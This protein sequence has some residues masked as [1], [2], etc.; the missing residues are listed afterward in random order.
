MSEYKSQHERE[1]RKDQ[2]KKDLDIAIQKL[3]ANRA[4]LDHLPD[5]FGFALDPYI[6]IIS[7]KGKSGDVKKF[8]IKKFVEDLATHIIETNKP[9]HLPTDIFEINT[10]ILPPDSG[11]TIETGSGTGI[12]EKQIIPRT[13]YVIEFFSQ[14]N[15]SY[16]NLFGE[17]NQGVMRNRE[18]VG[19]IVPEFQAIVLVNNEEGNATRIVFIDEEN[20]ASDVSEILGLTKQQLDS[21]PKLSVVKIN[22]PGNKDDFQISLLD[23]LTNPK[24]QTKK[25]STEKRSTSEKSEYSRPPE[26]WM[27]PKEICRKI[28]RASSWLPPAL[29]SITVTAEQTGTYLNKT[30][31]PSVYYSP[32]II[33]QLQKLIEQYDQPPNSWLHQRDISKLLG[34]SQRWVK[35]MLAS[36]DLQENQSGVFLNPANRPSDYYSSS[37]VEQLQKL[38]EKH[39]QPP[40]GWLNQ[41]DISKLLGKSQKWVKS[42]LASLDL[43]ENQSEV[44]LNLANRPSDY[45]SPLVVEQLTQLS[46]QYELPQEGWLHQRDISK[47]LGRS[48][49]WVKSKLGTL[50]IPNNQF[51]MFLT[52]RNQPFEYY[53]PL[54]VEQLKKIS[55]Q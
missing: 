8:N 21:H 34:R 16:K 17:M 31:Q 4:N 9:L 35:S 49:R 7:F 42:T 50:D 22:Y 30:N 15:I 52:A 37:V 48:D 46:K 11:R 44:F 2:I 36:L 55:E 19:F 38:A 29:A 26:G 41:W 5:M 3:V 27:N 43:Q 24:M 20:G 54:V 45:Y 23:A 33:E 28:N 13:E 51:G 47:L 10:M 1:A 12:E 14:H 25:S 32:E 40:N 53:S 39:E 6:E 18:Y